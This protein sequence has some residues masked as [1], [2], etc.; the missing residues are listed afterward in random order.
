M[1]RSRVINTHRPDVHGGGA[2]D[3]AD[4]Q[5]PRR[6]LDRD[7]GDGHLL[8]DHEGDPPALR[9]RRPRAGRRR[10]GQGAARPGCTR[11]CWSPSCTSRRCGRWPSPRRPGPT[12]SRAST[13]STDTDAT[14][15]L[16]SEWDERNIGVPLKVLHSPYREVVQPIVDYAMEIKQANPRGVVAVYIPEYVVGRWW[17]Q[18]LHNQTALRLKGR[19]LFAPG[20]MVTS[21]PYQ[22]RSS[23]IAV[24]REER[25]AGR[26]RPGDLR[27]GN[28]SDRS[29]SAAGRSSGD[30]SRTRNPRQRRA[31]GRSRVGER[32]TADVGPVAHGGHCVVR[33]RR[34]AARPGSSSSGTR[35][36][37]SGW[38]SRSPRAPRATG[39]GA[40]TR[41]RCSTPSPDRV[42]AP[43]PVAGPGLCGGCDFQH[44]DLARQR[45][46]KAEVVREQLSRLAGLDLDVVGRGRC[47][48]TR[49]GCAG[50]PGSG[51]SSCPTAGAGC[52]STARTTWSRSTTACSRRR[53]P[54]S[55]SV[56]GHDFSVAADGFWQV[57]PGAPRVLVET[58][59]DFLA[60]RPGE[61]VLDL[62]AGVGLFARF[63]A[64]AVGPAPGWS[65]SRATGRAA[66]HAA[67][68]P[69]SDGLD[70][71]RSRCAGPVDRVLAAAYD[72]PFD[73][74]V[75]DPPR[76]GAKRRV[77]E[78]VVDP[79]AARG[80]VRRLR[81]GRARPRRR[82]L[83]RARLPAGAAA[84]L[85]PVPDDPPRRVRRAAHSSVRLTWSAL[86]S[87]VSRP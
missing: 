83:R 57:H 26:V 65:R 69:G 40:A 76:E 12:C 22:L 62:Y 58:V 28:V 42:A 74:V 54:P 25:E 61:S 80:R 41:S 87:L 32:F 43:C 59:L 36:R 86:Q 73:L 50:G 45:A 72:E 4:H 35:S 64:D 39:S 63:L 14:N 52:A 56:L 85:R 60:P 24:E 75:L 17:E 15:R 44:V 23:Q 2:G 84:R 67:A 70:R 8:P 68:Q 53:T 9:Q 46:L 16:L 7:P 30:P 20:V 29:G 27:R 38:S 1:Q 79:G 34:R 78:Q 31:R 37:G 66:E 6:R 33:S 51:T 81:P 5:V 13:S 49:T 82:D 3:R 77:V 47:P 55:H 11:S 19:L 48:A 71:R 10:G 21:V 18:L